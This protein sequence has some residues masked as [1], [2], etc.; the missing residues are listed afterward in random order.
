MWINKSYRIVDVQTSLV[1]WINY[2][3]LITKIKQD[4]QFPDCIT[5]CIYMLHHLCHR[6]SWSKHYAY[7]PSL[8]PTDVEHL[9]AVRLMHGHLDTLEYR[10]L[11]ILINLIVKG[12]FDEGYL[13]CLPPVMFK[14]IV[15]KLTK[16]GVPHPIILKK[17]LHKYVSANAF[18]LGISWYSNQKPV[19][20]SAFDVWQDITKT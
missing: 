13:L 1:F 15:D 20:C 17:L 10:A 2:C 5:I 12:K 4:V 9:R 8:L 16:S 6:C 18:I 19:I 7:F 14:R 11:Q 3:C